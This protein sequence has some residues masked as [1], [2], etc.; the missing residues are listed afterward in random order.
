MTNQSTS[1]RATLTR[2]VFAASLALAAIAG[3]LPLA[4]AGLLNSNYDLKVRGYVLENGQSS[5]EEYGATNIPLDFGLHNVPN[6]L[7]PT[8]A[9]NPFTS[10][11]SRVNRVSGTAVGEVNNPASGL[12][13]EFWVRG[14]I[15]DLNNVFVNDLD[16]T[17]LVEV[18]M[19]FVWNNLPYGQQIVLDDVNLVKGLKYDA[20]S[21][22]TT[23]TGFAGD[24]NHPANP[25]VVLAKYNP[26]DVLQGAGSFMK[27]EFDYSTRPIPEP[28]TMALV[29]LGVLGMLGLLRK[30]K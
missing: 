23:G 13:I 2:R 22:Q 16:P 5:V 4:Q 9:P 27:V 8:P 21:V 24:A 11:A 26:A 10:T 7:S 28:A 25:L 17:K 19:K 30:R 12:N 20:V 18:E 6:T 15:N 3:S 14:P 1:R 29:G